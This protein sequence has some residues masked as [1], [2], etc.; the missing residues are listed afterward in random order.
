M[1][2]ISEMKRAIG[3]AV[4]D[5]GANA[6]DNGE[7][8]GSVHEDADEDDDDDD[9]TAAADNEEDETGAQA[10]DS[11]GEWSW[12]RVCFTI[13]GRCRMREN[14]KSRKRGFQTKFSHF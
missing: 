1:S 5:S 2:A 8:S 7:A 12:R 3:A 14:N 10:A 4:T 6:E 13:S 9:D 11:S